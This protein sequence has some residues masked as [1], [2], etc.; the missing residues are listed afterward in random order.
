MNKHKLRISSIS[1]VMI[2]VLVAVYQLV[3]I[4]R[5]FLLENG[6]F[7]NDISFIILSALLIVTVSIITYLLPM[8]TI[9]EFNLKIDFSL[10]PKVHYSY[11][12]QLQKH[13]VITESRRYFAISAY[14]DGLEMYKLFNIEY[15]LYELEQADNIYYKSPIYLI[16]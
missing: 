15:D 12:S 10:S 8:L 11:K 3:S 13:I 1:M 5:M 9:F 2:L 16:E 14:A 6:N 4:N 7:I